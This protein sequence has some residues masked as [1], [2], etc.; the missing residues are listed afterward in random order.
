MNTRSSSLNL[1]LIFGE[2]LDG[3]KTTCFPPLG[4]MIVCTMVKWLLLPTRQTNWQIC[5]DMSKMHY[6]NLPWI[7]Y[8]VF[9]MHFVLCIHMLE[10]II[11][12][13]ISGCISAI[14]YLSWLFFMQN[15]FLA[16]IEELVCHA[17]K[18]TKLFWP[19]L[20]V[21]DEYWFI[22]TPSNEW[23]MCSMSAICI[24]LF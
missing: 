7:I 4:T 14:S 17:W 19:N 23:W 15:V 22:A 11:F 1:I 10:N 13:E 6:G 8:F 21:W 3:F 2:R 18:Y 20:T 12:S 9:F 24:A 5:L 16:P